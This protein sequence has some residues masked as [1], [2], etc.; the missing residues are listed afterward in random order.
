LPVGIL[1]NRHHLNVNFVVLR[2]AGGISAVSLLMVSAGVSVATVAE[3]ST[4]LCGGSCGGNGGRGPRPISSGGPPLSTAGAGTSVLSA[5]KA[6]A[7]ATAAIANRAESFFHLVFL[8]KQVQKSRGRRQAGQSH[9][10]R[11]L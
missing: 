4:G 9:A 11:I 2:L 1:R 6:L 7:A 10:A 5:A 3:N 8:D